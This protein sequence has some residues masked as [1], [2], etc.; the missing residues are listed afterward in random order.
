MVQGIKFHLAFI[1]VNPLQFFLGAV[2][3]AAPE[4]TILIEVDVADL[5]LILNSTY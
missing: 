3:V 5:P 4:L 1:L 2:L